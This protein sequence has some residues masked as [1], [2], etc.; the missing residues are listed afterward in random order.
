MII[1]PLATRRLFFNYETF[2][3][4]TNDQETQMVSR[5]SWTTQKKMN[6]TEDNSKTPDFFF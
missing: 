3:S 2:C 1:D 4:E 5:V 6:Y